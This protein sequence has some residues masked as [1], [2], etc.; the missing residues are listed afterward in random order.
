MIRSRIQELYSLEQLS[1]GDTSVHR[2]HPMAKLISTA[3]FILIVVSFDRHAFGPLVP[4]VFFPTFM[5]AI[6]GTPYSMLLKRF[7]VALPFCLFAGV[8]NLVFDRDAAFSMY[9]ISVSYGA[10]SFCA[11]VLRSYLCVMS[12][13]VLV[14]VTPFSEITNSMRRLWVP[15]I[16]IVLFEMIYRYIG[17]LFDEA[18][19]MYVSYTLRRAGKGR[20]RG[21]GIA[22]RDMGS[23]LGQLVLRSIDRADRVYSAMKCRGYCG[24]H[25]ANRAFVAGGRG[26]GG[27]DAIYCVVTCSLFVAF[28]IF[29]LSIS[30]A[31]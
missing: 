22:I 24:G 18:Y 11:I 17:V 28:R 6:S 1:G 8:A 4:Y 25:Y 21:S 20:G 30:I 19:S 2:L 10:V 27:T 15:N 5:M 23:F 26:M 13:M 12:V 29:D 3:V 16:F 9:G 14:S 31:A 7:V